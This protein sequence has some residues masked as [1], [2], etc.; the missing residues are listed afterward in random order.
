MVQERFRSVSVA[1]SLR[2]NQYF[3]VVSACK[4]NQVAGQVVNLASGLIHVIS[5]LILIEKF[6][7][8]KPDSCIIF[9]SVVLQHWFP[10]RIMSY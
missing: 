2:E 4:E 6:S 10:N 3:V 1:Y 7:S 9:E 8:A 5:I